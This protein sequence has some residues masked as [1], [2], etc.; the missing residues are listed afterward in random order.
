MLNEENTLRKK[1]NEAG[2]LT[3]VCLNVPTYSC[4]EKQILNT[5]QMFENN[6]NVNFYLE[7][8]ESGYQFKCQDPSVL[9]L[10]GKSLK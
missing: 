9:D 4:S 8:H 3:I 5:L 1:T 6:K 2:S 10:M 7:L